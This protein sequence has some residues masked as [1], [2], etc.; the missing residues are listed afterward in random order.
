METWDWGIETRAGCHGGGGVMMAGTYLGIGNLDNYL[1]G[2]V[3]G[4]GF[5]PKL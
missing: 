4:G 1:E 5:S 2:Q 3:L